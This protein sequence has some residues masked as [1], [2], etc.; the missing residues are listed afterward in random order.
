MTDKYGQLLL[1]FDSSNEIKKK[2]R[3]IINYEELAVWIGDREITLKEL[4][5]KTGIY[6]SAIN[7][8]IDMLSINY[9][10]YDVR[11]GVYKMASPVRRK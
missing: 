9:T 7:N 2:P 1:D 8:V 6:T 11:H 4:K 5:E 3:R 10:L